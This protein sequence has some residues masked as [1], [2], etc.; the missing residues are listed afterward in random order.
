MIAELR[1]EEPRLFTPK[2][3]DMLR[4]MLEEGVAQEIQWDAM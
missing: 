1:K 2:M 4:S 3:V